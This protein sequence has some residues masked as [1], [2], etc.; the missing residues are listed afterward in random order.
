VSATAGAP[1]VCPPCPELRA[2]QRAKVLLILEPTAEDRQMWVDCWA[3]IDGPWLL[4]LDDE[5]TH[6]A[7]WPLQHIRCVEWQQPAVED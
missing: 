2:P 7:S 3:R 4:F 1:P 6:W 5:E